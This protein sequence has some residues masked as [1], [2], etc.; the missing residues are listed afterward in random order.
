M[1]WNRCPGIGGV[2][3]E[4]LTDGGVPRGAG[5][6]RRG[7]ARAKLMLAKTMDKLKG[8]PQAWPG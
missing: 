2:D 5:F 4:G 7:R 1:Y 6:V 8:M 3:V